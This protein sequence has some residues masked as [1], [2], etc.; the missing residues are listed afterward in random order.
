MTVQIA[1]IVSAI[2]IA[3]IVLI[4]LYVGAGAGKKEEGFQKGLY[5]IRSGYF[6]LLLFA[7]V[8]MLFLTL[9]SDLIPYPMAGSDQP[10]MV[11]DVKARVWSW[12]LERDVVPRDK[13]IEFAVH[14]EDVNHGFGI[15]DSDGKIVAQVQV[16]PGYTNRLRHRFDRSGEYT[17]LCMEY[18]GVAHH[19]MISGFTVVDEMPVGQEN[20]A[21]VEDGGV[22]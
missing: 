16:M 7:I 8:A 3:L 11:V 4:T 22:Q 10:D 6:F 1:A 12:E 20:A 9:R 2:V 5:K 19:K 17:I 13:L 18:C 14:S 15:Y 21:P